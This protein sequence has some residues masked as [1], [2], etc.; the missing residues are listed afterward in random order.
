MR[1]RERHLGTAQSP[2][3]TTSG[4][5]PPQTSPLENR[6]ATTVHFTGQ[7][8]NVQLQ[9]GNG[10]PLSIP[11]P[12]SEVVFSSTATSAT[13]TYTGGQ[14]VTTVPAGLHGQR[15][16]RRSSLPSPSRRLPA[17]A[18]ADWE[19]EFSGTT[20]SFTLQWQWAGGV[21]STLGSGLGTGIGSSAELPPSTMPSA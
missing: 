17:G 9:G 10:L 18:K 3:A 4:S 20:V 8:V 19:G 16:H 2:P 21:Y 5:A 14:W 7:W 6:H 11:A 12:N 13:T 15:L 1:D